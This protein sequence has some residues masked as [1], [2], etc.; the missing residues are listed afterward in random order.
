MLQLKAYG[1]HSFIGLLESSLQSHNKIE[2][3]RLFRPV[4]AD[5]TAALEGWV[6]ECYE[7]EVRQSTRRAIRL[8]NTARDHDPQQPFVVWWTGDGSRDAPIR[9]MVF[10]NHSIHDGKD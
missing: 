9:R 2:G 5:H 8:W 6:A 3:L 4:L 1:S 10:D 7:T